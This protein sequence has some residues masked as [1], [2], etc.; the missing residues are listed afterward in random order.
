MKIFTPTLLLLTLSFG[1]AVTSGAQT[2]SDNLLVS[3]PTLPAALPGCVD[4]PEMYRENCNQRI[5]RDHL[6]QHLKYP[7]DAKVKKIEGEVHVAL[8]IDKSGKVIQKRLD[9]KVDPILDAEA[10]RVVSLLTLE[11]MTWAPGTFKDRIVAS[12]YI[13]KIPFQLEKPGINMMVSPVNQK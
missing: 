9:K 12:E 7:E 10:L 11:N 13:I 6:D 8:V 5:L 4:M 2:L 1:Y 3:N